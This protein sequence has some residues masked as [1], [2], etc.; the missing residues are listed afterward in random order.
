MTCTLDDSAASSAWISW[1][2]TL[3]PTVGAVSPENS[4][5]RSSPAPRSP[6]WLPPMVSGAIATVL[7]DR[8][9]PEPFA[10]WPD[11]TPAA[12]TEP[13]SSRRLSRIMILFLYVGRRVK[14][15]GFR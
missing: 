10:A 12:D 3:V 13:D 11:R 14:P 9:L 5:Y 15:L 2:R 1:N 6:A 8:T 4:T 7:V